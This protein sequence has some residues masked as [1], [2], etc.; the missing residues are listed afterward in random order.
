MPRDKFH[1]GQRVIWTTPARNEYRATVISQRELRQCEESGRL[2]LAYWLDIDGLGSRGERGCRY[3]APEPEL[4]PIYD[5]DQ[6]VAWSE[7]AW[8]PRDLVNG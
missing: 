3:G 4:R 7:C 2:V 5:G 8:R 1:V 6:P